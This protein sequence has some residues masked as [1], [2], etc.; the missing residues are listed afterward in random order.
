MNPVLCCDHDN[1]REEH[2]YCHCDRLY[3]RKFTEVLT[4]YFLVI[5]IAV[6]KSI[7]IAAVTNNFSGRSLSYE[8]IT[9]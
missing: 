3:L 4:E 8:P 9:F 1:C 6:Q 5:I 7:C 2:L